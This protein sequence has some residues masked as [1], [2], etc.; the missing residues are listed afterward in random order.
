[1]H[2]SDIRPARFLD[3]PNR[4]IAHCQM[5]GEIV[6]AHVK[7]TGRCRELLI[8]GA[9]VYLSFSQNLNRRTP[10][11]LIAVQKGDRLVNMDS[12]A[13]NQ[14]FAEGLQTGRIQLPGQTG[15]VSSIQRET[16]YGASR[17]DFLVSAEDK[18]KKP[19]QAFIE[20]KGVTLEEDGAV[21]F[22]D[23]PTERGIKHL[24]ELMKAKA[25]GYGA[26]VAFVVQMKDVSYFM[27]NALRHAA[28]AQI[29]REASAAGV[30]I[31]V[32]DCRV[33]PDSIEIEKP[34]AIR[35]SVN[36]A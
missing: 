26:F 3:R 10:C 30:G 2:Y 23:A 33:T 20:V 25:E 32:Y 11:D 22:P 31:L 12:Q 9:P 34:V 24:K 6:T 8:P 4:F 35:L 21:L 27:P 16:R 13:P 36:D 1:M 18:E 15:P 14:V 7:N 29:L 28:F 19:W 5:N 17:L